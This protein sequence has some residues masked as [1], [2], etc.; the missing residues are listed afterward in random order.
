MNP[1][2][3][4]DAAVPINLADPTYPVWSQDGQFVALTSEGSNLSSTFTRNAFVFDPTTGAVQQIT[5]FSDGFVSGSGHVV[6]V[7]SKAFSP[8]GSQ[9]AVVAIEGTGNENTGY[10]YVPQI[11]LYDMQGNSKGIVE[12]CQEGKMHEGDGIQWAAGQN[13]LI[14]PDLVY[15]SGYTGKEPVTALVAY[16][17]VQSATKTRQL[18]SPHSA[19]TPDPNSVLAY[20]FDQD[21]KPAVGPL[22][23]RIAYVRQRTCISPYIT[24]STSIRTVN[25]DGTGDQ[26]IYPP[27]NGQP[28]H[29]LFVYHLNW[30]P[31]ESQLI[32]SYGTEDSGYFESASATIGLLNLDGTSKAIT[33]KGNA[34]PAWNPLGLEIL[35]KPA[36]ANL[37]PVLGKVGDKGFNLTVNG[38]NFAG[39]PAKVNL[40][41]SLASNTFSQSS[42]VLWNGKALSTTFVSPTQLKAA[43][44]A[45]DLTV[46]GMVKVTVSTPSPGGGVSSAAIFTVK[47]PSPVISGFSPASTGAGGTGFILTVSGSA[48]VNGSV[49]RWNG[50]SL[51]TTY[52]SSGK[53]K[54]KVPDADIATAGAFKITVANPSPGASVSAGMMFS[55]VNVS[56]SPNKATAGSASLVLTIDGAGF[57]AGSTVKWNGTALKTTYVSATRLQ[58][59][60]PATSLAK[61]GSAAVTVANPD[62]SKSR[63]L[64]F[65]IQSR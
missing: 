3:T 54:A 19:W 47:N 53:L 40:A 25:L 9:L 49:V 50:S 31:D 10:S 51:A 6:W 5:K 45:S 60:V 48:F 27:A 15:V 21:I 44:P 7:L 32:L 29:G 28:Q 1:D 33:Q 61:A 17:P 62:G 35:P 52:V 46:G 18:T 23:E 63:S 65:T 12:V 55:V 20:C 59:S 36:I 37:N 30:A 58:A 64:A 57:V 16:P 14:Y 8:D 38:K 11:Q 41:Q 24:P 56:L 39:L 34:C 4:G 22:T 43:V 26:Q 2:G 13:V 42:Q